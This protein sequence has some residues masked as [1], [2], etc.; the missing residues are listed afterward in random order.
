MQWNITFQTNFITTQRIKETQAAFQKLVLVKIHRWLNKS[1][2]A[3]PVQIIKGKTWITFFK[4]QPHIE[5]HR[6][7]VRGGESVLKAPS[8]ESLVLGHWI[9]QIVLSGFCL[10]QMSFTTLSQLG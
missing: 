4:S 2:Q 7:R 8:K 10:V 5:H 9:Q 6:V 1:S 3:M